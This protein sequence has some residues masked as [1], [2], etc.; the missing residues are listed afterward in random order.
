MTDPIDPEIS[1][2]LDQVAPFGGPATSL[3]ECAEAVV[4]RAELLARV[5]DSRASTPEAQHIAREAR[6]EAANAR[7]LVERGHRLAGTPIEAAHEPPF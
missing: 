6:E 7:L 2:L 3:A 1:D 4:R 5:I